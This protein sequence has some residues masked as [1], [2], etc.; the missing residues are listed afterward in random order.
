MKSEKKRV[1]V[2]VL[3]V[4]SKLS[5]IE[6]ALIKLIQHLLTLTIREWEAEGEEGGRPSYLRL[7]VGE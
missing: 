5:S 6:E 2:C 7:P 1:S 4:W 3:P